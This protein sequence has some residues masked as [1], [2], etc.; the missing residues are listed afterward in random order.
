MAELSVTLRE[1]STQ[2]V[3]LART[4]SDTNARVGLLDY[5]QWLLTKAQELEQRGHADEQKPH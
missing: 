5:A 4:M 2:V 1:K 3:Q